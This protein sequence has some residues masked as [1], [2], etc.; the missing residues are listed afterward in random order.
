LLGTSPHRYLVMRRLGRAKQLLLAGSRLAGAAVESGF[1]DQ[2]HLTR[3]FRDAFG[4]TPGRW[5]A[6]QDRKD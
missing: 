3:H 4:I 6:L 5:L 2:A 1:A